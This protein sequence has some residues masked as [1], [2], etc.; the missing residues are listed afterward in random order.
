MLSST[1]T[2]LKYSR[3]KLDDRTLIRVADS[4]QI[5][6]S[7][8]IAGKTVASFFASKREARGFLEHLIK[9]NIVAREQT[10]HIFGSGDTDADLLNINDDLK[11]V[12]FL[13]YTQAAESA[14]SIVKP[15]DVV[16]GHPLARTCNADIVVQALQRCRIVTEGK[17][18]VVIRSKI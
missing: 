17:Y 5:A 18:Y 3:K 1:I 13:I 10:R 16:T 6:Q 7:A 4:K 8:L 9:K 14:V 2:V 11:N 12:K 15:F